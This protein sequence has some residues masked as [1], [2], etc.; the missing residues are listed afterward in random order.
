MK[1]LTNEVEPEILSIEDEI[2]KDIREYI[3]LTQIMKCGKTNQAVEIGRRIRQTW[4]A[5]HGEK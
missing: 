2:L 3:Y 1:T 5:F 4:S